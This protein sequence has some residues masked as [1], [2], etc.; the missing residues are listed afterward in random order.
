MAP[1]WNELG[2]EYKDHTSVLIGDVDCTKQQSVCQE[3]G[4]RGYPTLKYFKAGNKEAQLY[5][6]KHQLP[7][8][9]L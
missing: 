7:T 1:A 4:V 3:Y 8:A 5:K 2:A 6:Y 9:A